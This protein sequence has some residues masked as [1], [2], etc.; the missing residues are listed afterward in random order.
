MNVHRN[1]E[2][3]AKFGLGAK[4]DALLLRLLELLRKAN[5]TPVTEKLPL[6][7]EASDRIDSLRF[8]LQILWENRSV[9]TEHYAAVA[10][11]LEDI[12]RNVG[13][14][15]KGLIEKTSAPETKPKAEERKQ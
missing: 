13:G 7:Q 4:I 9:S 2:R 15:K 1:I 10:A 11:D 14:W 5:Y 6:L 8:F 12:G 3:T